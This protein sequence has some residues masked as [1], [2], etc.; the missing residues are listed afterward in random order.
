MINEEFAVV[1]VPPPVRD[2]AEASM[3]NC[4]KGDKGSSKVT[5]PKAPQVYDLFEELK[6]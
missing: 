2:T 4:N 3:T 6:D 1:E 5:T